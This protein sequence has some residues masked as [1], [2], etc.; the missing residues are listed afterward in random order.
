MAGIIDES[1]DSE[2]TGADY[3]YLSK[4]PLQQIWF[5]S[6]GIIGYLKAPLNSAQRLGYIIGGLFLLLPS[7]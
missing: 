5:A 7:F 1:M 2:T 3:E 4:S 6:A